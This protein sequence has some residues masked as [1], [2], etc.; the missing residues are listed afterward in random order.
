MRIARNPGIMGVLA[1]CVIDGRFSKGYL[2]FRKGEYTRG[3]RVMAAFAQA[4]PPSETPR[5]AFHE[6]NVS[7]AAFH[8]SLA[9]RNMVELGL[10]PEEVHAAL[11]PYRVA[12]V[13]DT[14]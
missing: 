5:P 1:Q 13:H 11:T 8:Q 12:G 14:Q 9:Y 7:E 4:R 10:S 6:L 2:E 3:D